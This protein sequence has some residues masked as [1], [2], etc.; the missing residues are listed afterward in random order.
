[1]ETAAYAKTLKLQHMAQ[2]NSKSQNH[3]I[4]LLDLTVTILNVIFA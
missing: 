3:E 2:L 4:L 1:M